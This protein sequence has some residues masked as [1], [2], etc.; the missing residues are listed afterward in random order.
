[1]QSKDEEKLKQD[2]INEF[3]KLYPK[4]TQELSASYKQIPKFFKPVGFKIAK[5]NSYCNTF[6]TDIVS[7]DRRQVAQRGR[8]A[9]A[10]AARG[11]ARSLLAKE[12]QRT[13]Q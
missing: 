6:L 2:E 8:L 13:S 7:R 5:L 9:A 1:M 12:K 4:A 11:G 3:F 10:A